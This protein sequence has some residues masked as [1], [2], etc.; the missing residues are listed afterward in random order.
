[1]RKNFIDTKEIYTEE[2]LGIRLADLVN[3]EDS[4][5]NLSKAINIPISTLYD[6]PFWFTYNGQ[7][8]YYK[9]M[10]NAIRILN[11]LLGQYFSEYMD[12]PS[13]QYELALGKNGIEGVLSKNFREPEKTY[14]EASS[15][16]LY[17]YIYIDYLL[18]FI[19]GTNHELKK[20]LDALIVKDLFTCM[21][22]RHANTLCT[23]DEGLDLAP[24]FDYEYSLSLTD[25]NGNMRT[26]INYSN[27][28]FIK[29]PYYHGSSRIIDPQYLKKMMRHDKQISLYCEKMADVDINA[30]LEKISAERK[31][32]IPDKIVNHYETFYNDRKDSL[33]KILK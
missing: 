12:L 28:L 1:M 14:V 26:R 19:D 13:I 16:P 30:V 15:L 24:Q 32:V 10:S 8:Y 25:L 27:P 18:H 3:I 9:E 20:K 7:Y 17:Y 5:A 2:T 21:I 11:E 31:I 6:K 29:F 23:T 33:M 4:A 22:D